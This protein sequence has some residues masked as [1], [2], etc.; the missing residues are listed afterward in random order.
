MKFH[1]KHN[2]PPV[3]SSPSGTVSLTDSQYL[4][5]CD[6][7]YVM[8]KCALGDTSCI[9]TDKP[10]FADVSEIGDFV[11]SMNKLL[12]AR[13]AFENLPAE[14]RKKCGNDVRSFIEFVADP[15]NET[16]CIKYG[17]RKAPV[18]ETPVK[19][20]IVTDGTPQRDGLP[21]NT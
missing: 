6:I 21:P 10:L 5:D 18:N 2:R 14:L 8:K 12:E 7:N 15:S 19:V 3:V 1:T 16:E 17:L 20:E 9:R 13:T 4:N 11:K